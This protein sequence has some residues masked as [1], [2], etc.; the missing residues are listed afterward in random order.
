MNIKKN[1]RNISSWVILGILCSTMMMA[2]SAKIFGLLSAEELAL[3][4]KNNLASQIR[5]VGLLEFVVALLI[6]I[7]Y[8]SSLGVLLVSCFWGG[9]IVFHLTLDD[10]V[11]HMLPAAIFLTLAWIG[12]YL[13]NQ[14]LLSSFR[15]EKETRLALESELSDAQKIQASLLPKNT[16][17][18][19]GLL[20][21]GRNMAAKE[22]GGDFFDYLQ[23]EN[24]LLIAVGDVS[25]KGLKGAMNAVMASG[26]LNLSAKYQQ[27]I[28]E[29]MSDMNESLCQS[30][31]QDMNVTMIL[32]QF[33]TE[34]KQMILANAGQHAYPLLIRNGTV[35]LVQAK[36]LA[37]GMIPTISYKPTTVDL[38][39]GDLLLF[40]TDGITEPRNAKGVMYEESG[41]LNEVLLNIPVEMGIE[42][43]VDTIIN[44]VEA[45]TADEEQDDDITLVAVRV[46]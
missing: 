40:M 20:V 1:I 33:A 45:Y 22:V 12:S 2:S 39:S 34:K 38:E 35:E 24:S 41:R 36:G 46:S 30:I 3:W 6:I 21:A 29:I 37:L 19:E 23:K 16:L 26:I 17:S 4:E 25:G 43:V 14:D 15:K 7:P 18:V 44:D 9:A 13:R 32:A 28:N 8:T 10:P 27:S 31:E 5:M 11:T 42:E